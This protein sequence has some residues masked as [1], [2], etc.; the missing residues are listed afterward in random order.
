MALA[1]VQ[2]PLK[3]ELAVA[4]MDEQPV[5]PA[6]PYLSSPAGLT[7][8]HESSVLEL[9]CSLNQGEFQPA[10]TDLLSFQQCFRISIACEALF[11]RSW[12]LTI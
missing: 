11:W 9:A 5:R 12:Y 7:R 10:F 2:Y 1:S 6:V 4:F 3:F 8:N